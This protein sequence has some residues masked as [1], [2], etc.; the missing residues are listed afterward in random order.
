MISDLIQEDGRIS[1]S[2]IAVLS[3]ESEGYIDHVIREQT[4]FKRVIAK[5]V[6]K[7]LNDDQK[8]VRR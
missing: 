4:D 7:V 3:D 5:W 8:R 6:P 2:M 1:Q